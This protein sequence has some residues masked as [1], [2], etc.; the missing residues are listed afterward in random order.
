M[1]ENI[2]LVDLRAQMAEIVDGLAPDIERILT[3]AA[4]VGGPDVATFEQAYADFVGVRHCVGVANG[5]DGIELAVRA[6]GV[7]PGDEVILPA[8]T[9]IA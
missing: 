5:T 1:S 7:G 9:F 2:P 8:N 4:F 6:L 3:T